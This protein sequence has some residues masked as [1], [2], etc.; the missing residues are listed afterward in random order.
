MPTAI[1]AVADPGSVERGGYL[2]VL[3]APVPDAAELVLQALEDR[4]LV[5][6]GSTVAAG[7]EGSE[8]ALLTAPAARDMREHAAETLDSLTAVEA[9]ASVMDCVGAV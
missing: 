9:V 7:A 5:V 3:L 1:I 6:L 8:L 4:G 2:R